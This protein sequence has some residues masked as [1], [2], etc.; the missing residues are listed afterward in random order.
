[1]SSSHSV[2]QWI[3]SLKAGDLEAVHHLWSRYW[4]QLINRAKQHLGAS[5]KG[6][7]DEEDVAQNV[8][9]SFCRGAAAGR[10]HDVKNRDELWWLLLAITKQK[11][12]TSVR[13]ELAKKR[14]GG[15]VKLE[16]AMSHGEGERRDLS[17][18]RLIGDAPTPDLLAMLK[19]Q[20]THLLGVLRDDRLREIAR[21]RI[22]GYTVVEIAD[23]LAVTT[24]TVERKLQLIRNAWTK[25]LIR[26]ERE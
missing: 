15:R 19:E 13:R 11:S 24:R 12:V 14:G 10:F 3:A 16:S 26:A 17:L 2:S 5:P 8:F 21:S 4:P 7:A 9:L 22:E 20:N 18:D 6:M 23:E 25:E 1:M